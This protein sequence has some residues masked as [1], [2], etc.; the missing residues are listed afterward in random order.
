MGEG[1]ESGSSLEQ[2]IAKICDEQ[3]FQLSDIA[4]TRDEIAV[5]RI[6]GTSKERSRVSTCQS[7]HNA[8]RNNHECEATHSATTNLL[9][10][11]QY[12]VQQQT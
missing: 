9:D 3:T 4:N 5:S 8:T 7:T 10:I 1:G 2:S 11:Y 12:I 6:K